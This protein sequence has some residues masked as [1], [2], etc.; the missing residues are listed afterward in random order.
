MRTSKTRVPTMERKKLGYLAAA[1]HSRFR[2][3]NELATENPR[4]TIPPHS[5]C[6]TARGFDGVGLCGQNV[7]RPSLCGS[8]KL[9]QSRA[10]FALA[11][12]RDPRRCYRT[13]GH[14]VAC[15]MASQLILPFGSRVPRKTRSATPAP[16]IPNWSKLG[17]A[18]RCSCTQR[19]RGRNT[20]WTRRA[21][22]GASLPE[23]YTSHF[24][25]VV[26]AVLPAFV[27]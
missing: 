13:L 27:Y 19:S 24:F 4:K 3:N 14:I 22:Y 16:A 5:M 21:W 20:G 17:T 25:E 7:L 6:P 15:P 8:V 11:S 12:W 10:I 2:A 1:T 9:R 26:P 18:A 23:A